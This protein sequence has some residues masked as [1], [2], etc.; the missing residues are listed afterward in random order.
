MSLGK[1]TNGSAD[2][3]RRSE[4]GHQGNIAEVLLYDHVLSK[5]ERKKVERYVARKYRQNSAGSAGKGPPKDGLRLWLDGSDIDANPETPNPAPGEA[6]TSWVD[7]VGGLNLEQADAKRQPVMSKTGRLGTDAV[8]FDG[9]DQ[10][11]DLDVGKGKRSDEIAAILKTPA[12][13][14]S[15][16]QKA[17]LREFYLANDAPERFRLAWRK[18]AE[19]EKK[20][21]QAARAG[22]T[23]MVPVPRS[24]LWKR[25]R[26]PARRSCSS[27][28]STTSRPTK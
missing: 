20:R 28:A 1:F 9:Q 2:P 23:L 27:A 17:E 13:K 26:S 22:P 3:A 14:R 15:K 12:T 6:V 5:S 16:E 10:L 19:I 11:I 18:L 4:L 24:W 21:E 8:F 25:C 7:K